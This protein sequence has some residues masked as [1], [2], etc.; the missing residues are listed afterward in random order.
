VYKRGC[1]TLE[2]FKKTVTEEVAS[3]TPHSSKCIASLYKSLPK[4]MAMV[5]EM[6]G[7]KIGY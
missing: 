3:T 5:L 4:R 6:N 2:E 1:S 7:R